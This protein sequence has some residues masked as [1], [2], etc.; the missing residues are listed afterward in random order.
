MSFIIYYACCDAYGDVINIMW[1]RMIEESLLLEPNHIIP[2]VCDT[3]GG[4][5]L[6]YLPEEV[7]HNFCRMCILLSCIIC[8]VLFCQL[9]GL[10]WV[11]WAYIAANGK[12]VLIR[13]CDQPP[14]ALSLT[15][16]PYHNTD[17]EILST[18][19]AINAWCSPLPAVSVSKVT[20]DPLAPHAKKTCIMSKL[21]QCVY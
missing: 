6:G 16:P 13:I 15:Q 2:L 4:Y 3:S 9:S 11:A 21:G 20:L 8:N 18:T 14:L 12:C 19:I 7:G 1:V 5:M 17:Y 10:T